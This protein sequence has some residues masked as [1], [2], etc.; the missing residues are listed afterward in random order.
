MKRTPLLLLVATAVGIAASIG[1]GLTSAGGASTL[2]SNGDI[3]KV[4]ASIR[5]SLGT[6]RIV[7][8]AANGS[9]L[10][11]IL[12]RGNPADAA[13]SRWYGKVLAEAVATRLAAE[14]GGG[15]S[16]A[17]YDDGSGVD[18]NGGADVLQT[19]PAATPLAAGACE[20]AAHSQA[21]AADV[22]ISRVRT[23]DVL[24]GAC[25]F[26]VRPSGDKATF[27]A[28]ASTRLGTLLST[29]PSVQAHP[30]LVDV[31]DANGTTLLV[32]GWVPGLGGDIGQG[33]GWVRPG[34]PSSALLGSAP[35][36]EASGG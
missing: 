6:T 17:A 19:A 13:V 29:I 7:D 4:V 22:T 9:E 3:G 27:V 2:Q 30:Y 1:V 36:A 10:K 12:R 18:A 25:E 20:R 8:A 23:I 28:A 32:L 21:A 31:V 33:T 14:S 11:V 5:S 16:S 15:I 24:G 34:T 35:G 26:V